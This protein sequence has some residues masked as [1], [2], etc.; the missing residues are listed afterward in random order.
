MRSY[1]ENVDLDSGASYKYSAVWQRSHQCHF[2]EQ[3]GDLIVESFL[4]S[5]MRLPIL[6]WYDQFDHRLR[7]KY[8][9]LIPEFPAI[10]RYYIVIN[11]LVL[12]SSWNSMTISSEHYIFY[13][14]IADLLL[15]LSPSMRSY[16]RNGIQW[17]NSQVDQS[18]DPIYDEATISS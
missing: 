1:I 14:E 16:R 11:D 17:Q 5:T 7:L 18:R 9:D 10:T 4:F 15:E 6:A 3:D 12:Q 2:L 8:S 13:N